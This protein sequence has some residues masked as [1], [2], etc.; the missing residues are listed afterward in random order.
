MKNRCPKHIWIKEKVKVV[1]VI[2]LKA[3]LL[4]R[5]YPDSFDVEICFSCNKIRD[6]QPGPG[7]C[8]CGSLD[9]TKTLSGKLLCNV[10]NKFKR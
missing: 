1:P 6:I 10:C 2:K 9:F 7:L 5:V 3:G 8:D 4:N